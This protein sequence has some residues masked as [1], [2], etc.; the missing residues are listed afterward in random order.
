MSLL[1]SACVQKEVKYYKLTIL[2]DGPAESDQDV[3]TSIQ[4]L[5]NY[6]D[7]IIEADKVEYVLVPE[8]SV[9]RSD[10]QGYKAQS[11]VVPLSTLNEYRKSWDWLPADNLIGDYDE[12]IHKL[13]LPAAINQKATGNNAG[14]SIPAGI[15]QLMLDSNIVERIKLLKSE[16]AKEMLAKSIDSFSVSLSHY[17]KP[18][19]AEPSVVKPENKKD[20]VNNPVPPGHGKELPPVDPIR[21]M[22]PVVPYGIYKGPYNSRGQMHC[23]NEDA[24]LIFTSRH[25]ISDNDPRG[26]IAEPGDELVGR[27]I[28]GQLS[29]GKLYRN[30]KLIEVLYLGT[31]GD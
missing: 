4:H 19:V 7:T 28:N 8:V 27:W 3:S 16:I 24:R 30:K 15:K 13:V 12:N 21:P 9:V 5:C 2:L 29:Y 10:I 20:T 6:S 11:V 1:F 22:R 17:N 25:V 26:R 23:P 31:T 18:V 14:V